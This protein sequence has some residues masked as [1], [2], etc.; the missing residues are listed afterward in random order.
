LHTD[1]A[2]GRL[3]FIH[4]DALTADALFAAGDRSYALGGRPVPVPSA[5]HLVAMQVQAIK[6]DPL[7]AFQELA[8][9]QSLLQTQ[10]LDTTS[11]RRY[12]ERAGLLERFGE[13][14]KPL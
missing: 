7:R 10:R 1:P 4:V 11:V 13:L 6:N 14:E 12:F 8:D 9:I 2:L 3:D 5:E